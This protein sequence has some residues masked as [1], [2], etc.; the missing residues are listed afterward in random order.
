MERL[1]RR[2]EHALASEQQALDEIDAATSRHSAKELALKKKVAELEAEL[3]VVEE[4][5][6][7]WKQKALDSGSQ[8]RS[9]ARQSKLEVK[10]R[11]AVFNLSSI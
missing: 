2:L 3:R 11:V 8:L 5:M 4:S 9:M 7:E 10:R 6:R 1:R